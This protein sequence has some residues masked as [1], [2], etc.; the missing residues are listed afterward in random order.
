MGYLVPTD[1]PGLPKPAPIVQAPFRLSGTPLRQPGR[2]PTVGEQTDQ[3][4]AEAGYAPAEIEALRQD[5]V[6]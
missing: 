2:A 4:L 5:G 1:Y 3:I 6:I